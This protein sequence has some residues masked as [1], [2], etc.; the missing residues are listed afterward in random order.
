MS[1]QDQ[2]AKLMNIIS[3]AD[4]YA[5]QGCGPAHILYR[6][7]VQLRAMFGAIPAEIPLKVWHAMSERKLIDAIKEHRAATGSTL[8]EAKDAVDAWNAK[9]FAT[10]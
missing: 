10:A 6:E 4:Q 2:I 9:Y 1:E 5:S 7:L 8:K 3:M